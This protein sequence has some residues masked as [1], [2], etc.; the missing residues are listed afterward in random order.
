MMSCPW[1]PENS[2]ELLEH[3]VEE[4]VVAVRKMMMH[5]LQM[6]LSLIIFINDCRNCDKFQKVDTIA[7]IKLR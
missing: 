4:V 5:H 1:Y 7:T 6:V 3:H 2:P